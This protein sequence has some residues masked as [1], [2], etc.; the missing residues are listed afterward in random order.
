MTMGS[1]PAPSVFSSPTHLSKTSPAQQLL[2]PAGA[3]AGSAARTLLCTLT[4]T[5]TELTHPLHD[6][7]AQLLPPSLSLTL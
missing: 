7:E 2:L 4:R 6:C 3:H 1:R 5:L